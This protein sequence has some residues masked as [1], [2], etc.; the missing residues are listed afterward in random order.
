M[1][2]FT[3]KWDIKEVEEG[4]LVR[5]FLKTKGI[6]KAA[7]TD[8]KFHGGAIEVNGEHA[9]V[10]HMLQT[11]EELKVFF[12][13]EARSEGMEAENIPLCIVYEDDAVLVMNKEA[14][15]S[16]IP[17]R[18]HPSG[19]VAN[20]LLYHYDKQNLA[21]TVHIVTRLDRDTSGLMLIAKNRF[22]HHL[23]SRQH[24]QKQVKRTY[25]AIVHGELSDEAGTIDAPIGRKAD[26]I[27]ERTVCE[28]GQRAVT[29]FRVIESS[30]NQTLVA[31]EL[32]T[33]RT[34]QIRVH[35]AHIGHP[36]LGDDLYGG[37]RD[38]IKRQALHSTSLTFYH[39]IL[40]KE[41]SFFA[42]IPSDMQEVLRE[43]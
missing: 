18:E 3:L 28:E 20:A 22:V 31:L 34:H 39:P 42:S 6:S 33:G 12:P 38:V 10:R 24:Q 37:Q 23:L 29:H 40:E 17:S 43:D 1:N 9:S 30:S 26:S 4:I 2:R 36:L 7:L 32:E 8:I 16:T 11:G 35:M 13:V 14:Y 19:S 21:S 41:M 15:M 5:E 27:I 25:E